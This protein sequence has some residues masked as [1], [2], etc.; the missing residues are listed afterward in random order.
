MTIRIV[1][2]PPGEAPEEVRAAWVGLTLPLSRS[3]RA[4]DTRIFGVQTGPRN[5]LMARLGTLF[6]RGTRERGYPVDARVAIEIL[7]RHAPSAAAWWREHAAHLL[8]PGV[9][10]VFNESACEL[11]GGPETG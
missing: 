4:V 10:F 8:R 6:R 1:S 7:S 2:I 3:D 11:I 5:R 9:N